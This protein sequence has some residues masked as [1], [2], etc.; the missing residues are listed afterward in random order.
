MSNLSNNRH[1]SIATVEPAASEGIRSRMQAV[2]WEQGLHMEALANLA[3]ELRSPLQAILG[4]LD[5][6]RDELSEEIGARHQ[7][8]IE[9][10]NANAHDLAQTVENVMDFSVA[11][12]MAEAAGEE[13]IR[14][15][16]LI[17]ELAPALEAANDSKRLEIRFELETAPTV[18]RSRRRPI[19]SILLNLAINAIKFTDRGSV[20]IG[21]HRAVTSQLGSAVELEVRDTGPGIE[22]AM[23][24]QAF[25]RC[26]QLSHSSIRSHRG[27]GLGLAVVQR[28]VE[29]LGAK[30][31][32][33]AA[34]PQ[35]TVFI[36]IIPIAD[37]IADAP[38]SIRT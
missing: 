30:I 25:E 3:H 27:M 9:R 33:K 1:A 6:L 5:I 8:I 14:L 35:G 15:Q 10:M 17:G 26:A 7:Q 16:D 38:R 19:K 28:N 12:A 21:V 11:D 13:E 32:V 29:V 37:P 20:T 18:F 22:A 31:I 24:A 4:Y 2:Q 23:L 36:V 34:L